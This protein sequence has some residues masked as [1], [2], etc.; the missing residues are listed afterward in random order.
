MCKF[1]YLRDYEFL[2]EL[3]QLQIKTQYI[4][5][6]ALNQYDYPIKEIEGIC[7]SG[8]L[9]INAKSVIRRSGSLSMVSV[10][11]VENITD[12]E[13]LISINK[14]IAIQ[15]G[16]KNSTNSYLEYETFWFPLGVF[17][18]TSAQVTNNKNGVNISI[19]FKD[20]MVLLNGEVGG[21]LSG[22]ITHSPIY[23]EKTGSTEITK[24]P[25]KLY[26]LIYE[27]LT[28]FGGIP[29]EQIIIEN[30]DTRVK[31]T[32]QWV[33]NTDIWIYPSKTFYTKTISYEFSL[34]RPTFLNNPDNYKYSYGE[35]IG[36]INTDFVY[37]TKDDLTSAAGEAITSLLDKIKNLLGNYE[38]F[39]DID[40]I[41]HFQEIKNGLNEGSPI[42][43]LSEAIGD[44][45]LA[46]RVEAKEFYNFDNTNL[47]DSYSNNPQ[48]S[49]VKNA[50]LVWGER[51]ESK[52]PIRYHLVIDTPPKITSAV[53]ETFN[54]YLRQTSYFVDG[55]QKTYKRAYRTQQAP[56]DE[57]ASITVE[58]GDD[59]RLLL[60]YYFITE[61][62]D[63]P[64]KKEFIEEFPKI[65]DIETKKWLVT[66]PSLLNYFF[67]MLDPKAIQHP[68]IS[69][70]GVDSIGYRLKTFTDKT[71]NTL[72]TPKFPNLVFIETGLENTS[73]LRKEAIT[74]EQ[75]Y[76]QVPKHVADNLATGSSAN[77]AFNYIR[78]C[79]HEYLGYSESISLSCIPIFY[80]EPNA[81]IKVSDQKSSIYGDFIIQ[82]MSIPLAPS[83][84]MS[85]SATRAIE[86]I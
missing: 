3:D 80:L 8:S 73:D 68:V 44:K 60:Y 74:K 86:R 54:V 37:P 47:I 12:I 27:L 57:S 9:S 67:D 53:R 83:S 70:M 4:K 48:Y 7:T 66:D 1:N 5:I 85:I 79:I 36:Y 55:V 29:K 50:F 19:S 20:K 51:E 71:V 33:G 59:W 6:I 43:D 24:E 69:Q 72:F 64:Y 63:A 14:R 28:E 62:R 17:V 61:Q 65:F 15:I 32:V 34:S 35:N 23:V 45:Y 39:F 26:T 40:G 81:R 42:E 25:V 49:K 56:S 11:E 46:S 16:I 18:L 41:F 13:N 22:A 31:N 21:T 58:Q 77:S 78:S 2:K 82:S 10:S 75:S 84:M 30:I 52:L 76:I 38:Y